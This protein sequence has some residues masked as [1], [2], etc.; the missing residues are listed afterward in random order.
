[1][2][3]KPWRKTTLSLLAALLASNCAPV[4]GGGAFCDIV[5]APIVF[6]AAVAEVVVRDDRQ[7]AVRIDAQNRYGEAHCGW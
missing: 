6:D 1:M 4:S 2:K 5:S 3:P 7:T